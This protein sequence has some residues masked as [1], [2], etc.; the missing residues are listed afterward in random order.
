VYAVAAVNP[1]TVI[2]PDVAW[3]TDPVRPL[4]VDVAVYE[5]IAVPPLLPGAV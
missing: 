5:V 1:V 2:V 4:G 3:E